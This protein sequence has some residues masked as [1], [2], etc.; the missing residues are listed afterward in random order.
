MGKPIP[1]FTANPIMKNVTIVRIT[2]RIN[3]MVLLVY[4]CFL[5]PYRKHE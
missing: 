5:V 3:D 2:P 4:N 1:A